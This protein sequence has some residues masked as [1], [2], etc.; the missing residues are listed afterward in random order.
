MAAA[1]FAA[2]SESPAIAS[3]RNKAENGNAIAQ[4][5]L[6]L[7]YATGR[8]VQ[9]DQAEAFV[10]L[11]LA[12]EQG[13]TGKDLDNLLSGMSPEMLTEAKRRLAA[14][15]TVIGMPA[16]AA[17]AGPGP[18]PVAAAAPAPDSKAVSGPQGAQAPAPTPDPE[19]DQLRS[20]V[21]DLEDSLAQ[22]AAANQQVSH[23]LDERGQ[24]LLQALT[25]LSALKNLQASQDAAK[26][27]EL[28]TARAALEAAKVA[29]RDA[30]KESAAQIGTLEKNLEASSAEVAKLTATVESDEAALK[31]AGNAGSGAQAVG[32]ELEKTKEALA[33]ALRSAVADKNAA[34]SKIAAL[35][36]DLARQTGKVQDLSA[37]LAADEAAAKAAEG[38][39]ARIQALS[40]ELAQAKGD[41]ASA[42]DQLARATQ[43]A[44]AAAAA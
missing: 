8:G 39:S 4:Y 27:T 41:L 33:T 6:G 11:T 7:A 32:S 12:A 37:K 10:W 36:Q 14:E 42:R 26:E 3:L 21:K 34:D 9:V 43:A 29:L 24:A 40:F 16:P 5:N 15:R 18:T 2:D 25:Q 35:E 28:S 19:L 17:P 23:Q 13:S 38:A 31:S 30:K 20:K 44:S 22:Q 1:V